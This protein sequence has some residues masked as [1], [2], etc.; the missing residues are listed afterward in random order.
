MI[1]TLIGSYVFRVPLFS[2]HLNITILFFSIFLSYKTDSTNPITTPW[3]VMAPPG[4]KNKNDLD[5]SALF[6]VMFLWL[7]W[8]DYKSFKPDFGE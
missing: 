1:L 3:K 6:F 2:V 7:S 5:I 8:E 4:H